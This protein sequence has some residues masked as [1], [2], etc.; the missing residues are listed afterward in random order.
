MTNNSNNSIIV[1]YEWGDDN[2]PNL[3][4]CDILIIANSFYNKCKIY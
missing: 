2:M 4:D 1:R 3:S